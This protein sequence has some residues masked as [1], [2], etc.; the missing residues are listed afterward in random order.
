[1]EILL[2]FLI[3]ET[4]TFDGNRNSLDFL[5]DGGFIDS[6]LTSRQLMNKIYRGFQLMKFRMKLNFE[7]ALK[8]K[9]FGEL[10]LNAILVTYLD[11]E[12]AGLI[13]NPYPKPKY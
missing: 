1:M 6:T 3:S 11:R 7:M 13:T 4:N 12:K 10:W 5:K 2:K 9:T 8:K